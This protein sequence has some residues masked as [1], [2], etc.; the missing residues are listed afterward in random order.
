MRSL[1]PAVVFGVKGKEKAET[2]FRAEANEEKI[3]MYIYKRADTYVEYFPNC[4]FHV[5]NFII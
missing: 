1:F 4:C 5:Q 2:R 3:F